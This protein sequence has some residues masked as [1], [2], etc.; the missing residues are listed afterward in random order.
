MDNVFEDLTSS[1]E[2]KQIELVNQIDPAS[3]VLA[4]PGALLQIITNLVDNAIRHIP[5]QRRVVIRSVD[6]NGRS[7]IYVEDNGAGIAEKYRSRVFERFFRVDKG[8]A[9]AVGGTGLGLSI[10]RHL[11][12]G[13]GGDIRVE[14]SAEGG[15]CFVISLDC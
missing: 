14:E 3:R 6:V 13:M 5:E 9:R 8:R 15:A 11:V 10:V 7:S 1:A 12:E 4:D 2:A